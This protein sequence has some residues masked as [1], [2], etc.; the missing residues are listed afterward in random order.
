MASTLAPKIHRYEET[1]RTAR[2]HPSFAGVT[3]EVALHGDTVRAWLYE[4]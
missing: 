4:E 1:D 3:I 2:I